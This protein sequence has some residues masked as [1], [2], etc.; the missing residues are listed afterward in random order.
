MISFKI[1]IDE[2]FKEPLSDLKK[3]YIQTKNLRMNQTQSLMNK[4]ILDNTA[5]NISNYFH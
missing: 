5:L 4:P 2:I 3:N 1:G